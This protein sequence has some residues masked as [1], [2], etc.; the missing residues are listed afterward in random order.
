MSCP[1]SAPLHVLSD[2][3]GTA[4]HAELLPLLLL[5][6]PP[7]SILNS[8][9]QFTLSYS[10]SFGQHVAVIGSSPQLGCWDAQ[11][12][13]PLTW[14]AGDAWKGRLPLTIPQDR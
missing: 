7:F 14:H 13:V 5:L 4:I 2:I 12:A 9:P 10:C 11:Q 8:F 6:L 3:A 1:A